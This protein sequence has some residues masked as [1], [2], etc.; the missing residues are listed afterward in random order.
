MPSSTHYSWWTVSDSQPYWL[1]HSY[2]TQGLDPHEST[3][4]ELLHTFLLGICKYLW[5]HTVKILEKKPNTKAGHAQMDA[6][7]KDGLNIPLIPSA[8]IVQ[9]KYSL[10][11]KHFCLLI[12]TM[13]FL[14]EDLVDGEVLEAWVMLG[15]AAVQLWWTDIQEPDLYLV[16]LILELVHAFVCIDP[17]KIMSKSK[18]H[19]LH[20]IVQHIHCNRPAL[21]FSTE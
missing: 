4:V 14:I 6:L 3:L 8:Y 1:H 12:Q 2:P 13:P 10:I 15:L 16:H 17:I 9:Y 11:S 21:L 20:H 19:I 5:G 18:L 7:S